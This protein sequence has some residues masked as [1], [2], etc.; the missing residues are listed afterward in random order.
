MESQPYQ[1]S[2]YRNDS[3]WDTN[4]TYRQIQPEQAV[5]YIAGGPLAP[6]IRGTVTFTRAMGGTEVSVEVHGLPPY[7]PATNGKAPVGPHGFHI[8][9]IG[10]C[11][12]GDPAEPFT[13]AGGHWNPTHQPHGNHAGDFPVLFSNNGYSRMTFFTNQFSVDQIIGKAVI[14]HEHPYDYRTQPDGAG[15]HRLACGV[16]QENG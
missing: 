15:G 13:S 16:I 7:Q 1:D 5:A 2:A 14:I 6:G 9:E 4:D 12:T 10:S 3:Y 8:H 11:V